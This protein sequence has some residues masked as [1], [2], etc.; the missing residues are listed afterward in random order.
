MNQDTA[1]DDLHRLHKLLCSDSSSMK[2]HYLVMSLFRDKDI[3]NSNHICAKE[4]L[5][6]VNTKDEISQ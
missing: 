6:L 1:L 3:S 2:V 4:K 5:P